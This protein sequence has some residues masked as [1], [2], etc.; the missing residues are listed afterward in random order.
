MFGADAALGPARSA[1][2]CVNHGHG[3][4]CRGPRVNRTQAEEEESNRMSSGG[5]ARTRRRATSPTQR[6]AEREAARW[7]A[8]ESGCGAETADMLNRSL[9]DPDLSRIAD[10][11]GQACM[12]ACGS[13]GSE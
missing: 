9:N 10:A 11:Y 3:D 13:G 2:A 5:P 8:C 12:R 4:S 7:A 6:A 1:S